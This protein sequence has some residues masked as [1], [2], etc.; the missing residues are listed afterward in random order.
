MIVT[1]ERESVNMVTLSYNKKEWVSR[2]THFDC[3][4]K[5]TN[6]DFLDNI[7]GVRY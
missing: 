4:D 7:L 3:K 6:S 1:F 2:Q 5:N